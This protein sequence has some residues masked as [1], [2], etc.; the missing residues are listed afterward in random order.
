MIRVIG[1]DPG[2]INMGYGIVDEED[3]ELKLVACGVISLLSKIPIENRLHAFYLK[4]NKIISEF[5]PDEAAVEE[6]FVSTN[7]RSA[8]AIGRAQA[9]VILA[10]AES[11]IP[12]CR[13]MPSEIKLQ[14]TN[15]GHSS[16]EQVIEMVKLQLKQEKPLKSSDAADALAI[17]ICHINNRHIKNLINNY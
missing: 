9:I 1:I 11:K 7:V 6:P 2:T 15:N 14:V 13:Y 5:Q 4:I 16:K 12:I 17:A 10:A 3:G 8:F